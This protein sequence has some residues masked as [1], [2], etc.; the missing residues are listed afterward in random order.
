MKNIIEKLKDFI[1]FR[2]YPIFPLETQNKMIY[3]TRVYA[4]KRNFTH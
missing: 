1:Y 3:N 4:Q 2:I